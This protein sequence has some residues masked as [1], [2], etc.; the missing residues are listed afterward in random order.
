[1]QDFD[2]IVVGAGPAGLR[3]ASRLARARLRVLCLEKKQEI[4]VPKRCAEGLG[5]GWVKAL[6]LKPNRRWAL[7]EIDGAALYAPSGK[8]LELRFNE[9][10]GYI[11]ERR[12]FEKEL[13]IGASLG[14]ALIKTKADAFAFERQNGKV[15]VQVSEGSAVREYRAPLV[16]ACDG[17]E[18][19]TARRLGLNTAIKLADYDSGFQYEMVGVDISDER[20][21]HLYFGNEIAR[22]GYVWVFPKGKHHANV[23]IGIGGTTEKTA[24]A[25]LDSFLE[26]HPEL[27][28][29]SVIEVNC[30]CVPVGGFLEDMAADNLLVVGDAAHQVNPIHGGGIGIAMEAADIAASV[31]IKAFAAK[32][33][34]HDFLKRY[35]QLWYEK[36][37]NRLKAILKKRM[38]FESLEDKDFETLAD[39]I[40]GE[41]V[42]KLSEADLVEAAKVVTKKLVKHPRLVRIMLRYLR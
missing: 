17:V 29:G 14:G 36:R 38:M 3:A 32:D 4:G 2:A 37:G 6:G 13:A 1:M 18:S 22:R 15:L 19:M 16:I 41:D 20:L 35:N 26:S 10:S 7:Q 34:S 11:I 9:T 27:S 33:F 12:V 24:K 21:I 5:M 42:L 31:A 25:C 8:K 39:S 23:G 40:S 30:G 28:K